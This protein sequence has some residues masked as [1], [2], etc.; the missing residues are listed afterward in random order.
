MAVKDRLH[1]AKNPLA[2]LQLPEINM[3]EVEDSPMLW[4]PLRFLEACPSSDGACAMV[5]AN[6]EL[7]AQSPGK[8]AWIRG[9]KFREQDTAREAAVDLLSTRRRARH[10]PARR[11]GSAE[12]ER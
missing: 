8:P 1:G 9:A 7:A 5:I 11:T 4:E 12:G 10:H 6:E 3:K 2:H